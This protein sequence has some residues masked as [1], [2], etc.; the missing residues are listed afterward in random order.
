M[1][2]GKDRTNTMTYSTLLLDFDHTLFDSDTS[3][4]TTLQTRSGSAE[5]LTQAPTST[6]TRRS[7]GPSGQQSNKDTS[8]RMTYA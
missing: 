3:E 8:T 2:I 6:P 1:A 4:A 5:S 7:I